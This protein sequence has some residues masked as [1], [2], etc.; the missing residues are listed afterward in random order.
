[1]YPKIIINYTVMNEQ[2]KSGNAKALKYLGYFALSILALALWYVSLPSLALWYVWKKTKVSQN[3]KIILTI[4]L[5]VLAI[6]GLASQSSDAPVAQPQNVAVQSV[7]KSDNDARPGA[8]EKPAKKANIVVSSQI[9][10]KVGGK[11]RYFFDI[12]N[13]DKAS[14]N[15]KVVIS[16]YNENQASALGKETFETSASIEPG[17]GNFVFLE[18]NT[19]PKAS[20]GEYG[21]A[22]F[23]YE[24]EASDGGTNSGGSVVTGKFEDLSL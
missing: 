3:A 14:F 13:K 1:M 23:K 4:P 6:V 16:L 2:N 10:K 8:P 5:L 17:M 24:V 7:A 21:I 12:R 18:I 9:V 11:Y 15:G 22:S 19:G 20:F